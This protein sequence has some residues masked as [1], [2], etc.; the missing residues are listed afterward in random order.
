MVLNGAFCPTEED[1]D[2]AMSREP[3]A[4]AEEEPVDR[5]EAFHM[6][7]IITSV[8]RKVG[9][10][11]SALLFVLCRFTGYMNSSVSWIHSQEHGVQQ[12]MLFDFEASEIPNSQDLWA[13]TLKARRY[14]RY[15]YN[16][17]FGSMD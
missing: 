4:K 17:P 1:T 3:T 6:D 12:L 11:E 8:L 5:A 15:S 10:S 16:P 13:E 14:G 9:P 2:T 7:Q